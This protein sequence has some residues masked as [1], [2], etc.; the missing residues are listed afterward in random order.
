MLFQHYWKIFKLSNDRVTHQVTIIQLTII[1]SRKNVQKLF[2]VIKSDWRN[3]AQI[4]RIQFLKEGKC[5]G[6]DP[7][8]YGISVRILQ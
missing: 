1:Y 7:S 2:K 6:R 8:L 4:E 3:E 5:T